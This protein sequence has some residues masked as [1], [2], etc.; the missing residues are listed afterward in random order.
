MMPRLY[1]YVYPLSHHQLKESEKNPFKTKLKR[2]KKVVRVVHSLKHFLDP[3]ICRV[4]VIRTLSIKLI[5]RAEM[6]PL[7]NVS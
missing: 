2:K 7:G 5:K 1:G 3:H 6:K 4:M